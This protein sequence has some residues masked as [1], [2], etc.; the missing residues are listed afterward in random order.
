MVL[1]KY[2]LHLIVYSLA[3]Q[4]GEHSHFASDAK[5]GQCT[6]GARWEL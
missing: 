5:G 6:C 1:I 3:G 4:Y 2:W